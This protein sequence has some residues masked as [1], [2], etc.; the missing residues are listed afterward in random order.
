MKWTNVLK[1]HNVKPTKLPWPN[2]TLMYFTSHIKFYICYF[3]ILFK[4]LIFNHTLTPSLEGFQSLEEK[5]R[6]KMVDLTFLA[7][8]NCMLNIFTQ[9]PT[10]KVYKCSK[11]LILLL[12]NKS[13]CWTPITHTSFSKLVWLVVLTNNRYGLLNCNSMYIFEHLLYLFAN[14][15]LHSTNNLGGALKLHKPNIWHLDVDKSPCMQVCFA[16]LCLFEGS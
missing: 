10:C 8:Q 16:M 9:I 15:V 14:L 1:V 5:P 3:V 6:S 4:V 12:F 7:F 2:W 13:I 11:C